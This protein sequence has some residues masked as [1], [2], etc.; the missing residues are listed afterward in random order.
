MLCN[1]CQWY[2]NGECSNKDSKWYEENV[3]GSSACSL[4]E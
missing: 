4:A 2:D 1:S 3:D